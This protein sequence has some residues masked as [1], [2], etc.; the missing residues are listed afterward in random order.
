MTAP[1]QTRFN[2]VLLVDGD[3]RTSQRLAKL[4]RED[5]FDVEVLRDGATAIARLTRAPLPDVLITEL[6]LPLCDGSAVVRF[7]R[8][9]HAGLS[10]VVLTGYPN[11]MAPEAFG[12]PAPVLLTKPLDYS[13]LLDVLNGRDSSGHDRSTPTSARRS[14]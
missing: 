5:G 2:K 3:L 6:K 14:A 4:L 1:A 13:A 7:G 10:V 8:S 11:L 9:Q 12:S